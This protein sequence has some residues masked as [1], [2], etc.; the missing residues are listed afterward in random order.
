MSNPV[1]TRQGLAFGTSGSNI[2]SGMV[3]IQG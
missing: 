3:K 2:K 1:G